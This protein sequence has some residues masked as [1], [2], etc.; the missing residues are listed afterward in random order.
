DAAD[1]R[2]ATEP[3]V[4]GEAGLADRAQLTVR[5]GG[6]T[7]ALLGT[8]IGLGALPL[9]VHQRGETG[10]VDL[11]ALF[12]GH[13]Q[14]EVDR[15]AV[16]VVQL[17]RLLTGEHAAATGADLAYGGVEDLGAGGEGARERL[18]LGVGGPGDAVEVVGDLRVRLRHRI[19]ADREQFG[20]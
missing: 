9:L 8:G 4:A 12:G 18:L 6:G 13:L 17:E 10:L 14:G 20:E 3:V 2:L 5:L 19:A 7:A 1:P 15:E 11:E 16:R